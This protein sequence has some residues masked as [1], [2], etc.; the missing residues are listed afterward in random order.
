MDLLE[1][2][3][4]SGVPPLNAQEAVLAVPDGLATLYRVADAGHQVLRDAPD[5]VE[6]LL[7]PF[8]SGCAATRGGT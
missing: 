5:V 6:D 8:V 4:P 1:S 2:P 7:R 3:V